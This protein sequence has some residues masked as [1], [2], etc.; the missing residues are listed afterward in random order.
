MNKVLII[1]ASAEHIHGIVALLPRLAD[2]DVPSHRVATDL[3]HGD[4]DLLRAWASGQ[5]GDV[6]VCVATDET[7]DV[8]GVAAASEREDLLSHAPSAHLEVLSVA[9]HAERQGLG[10]RLL[11]SIEQTMRDKGA[12]GM[13]LHVFGNNHQARALYVREGFDE[14]IVRCFK[15]FE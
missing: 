9:K 4:A 2:F 10:H 13:S 8:L 14:E 1:P 6:S 15:Q 5:R 7:G 11:A 3:W 12:T